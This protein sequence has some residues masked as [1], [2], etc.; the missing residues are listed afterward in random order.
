MK[1]F[2]KEEFDEKLANT[3]EAFKSFDKFELKDL[4]AS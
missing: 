4:K 2:N 3:Q 1:K